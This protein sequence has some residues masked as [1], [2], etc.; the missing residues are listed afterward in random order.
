MN[1]LNGANY[2]YIGDAYIEL[3][4]RDFLLRKGITKSETLHKEAT[5]YTSGMNQAKFVEYLISNNHLTEEEINY[6]K[7]GRNSNTNQNRKNIDIEN[8]KKATGFE[9][10]IGFL[11]YENNIKRIEEIFDLMKKWVIL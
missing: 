5:K 3:V 2:A 6:F 1:K 10:I 11:Y 9:A 8:Y 4:I 7:K